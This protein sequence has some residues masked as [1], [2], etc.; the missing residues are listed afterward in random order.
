M[1]V[2]INGDDYDATL[3]KTAVENSNSDLMTWNLIF[4]NCEWTTGDVLHLA[5]DNPIAHGSDEWAFSTSAPSSV[6][7]TDDDV[8][9]INVFPNPYYGTHELEV[10]RSNK[11]VTFNHLPQVAEIRIF[12]LGGN[13]V[14]QI[15]KDDETQYATWDLKNQFGYPVASGVYV[16]HI[17][18]PDLDKEKILKFAL[19]QEEQVLISY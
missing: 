15:D 12:N 10:I 16:M 6:G 18:L 17:T 9:M 11:Y 3:A 2:W 14:A 1:Y 4:W 7:I 13:M 19:V 5:Y 8:D